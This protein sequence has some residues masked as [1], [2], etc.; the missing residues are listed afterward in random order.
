MSEHQDDPCTHAPSDPEKASEADRECAKRQADKEATLKGHAPVKIDF[1]TFVFSLAT[2]AFVSLG[3]T[4]LTGEPGPAGPP[5]LDAAKQLI[6]ILEMLQEK[7]R[8]NLSENEAHL[9]ATLLYDLRMRYVQV[10]RGTK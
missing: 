5:D 1:T 10:A 8:G 7:S 9:L 2:Q 6:D 4:Q 3:E